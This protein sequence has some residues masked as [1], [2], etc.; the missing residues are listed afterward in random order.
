MLIVSTRW[1]VVTGLLF[2][3]LAPTPAAEAARRSLVAVVAEVFQSLVDSRQRRLETVPLVGKLPR[4]GLLARIA[5][6]EAG[7][8]ER[9][10]A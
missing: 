1:F 5:F 10:Q 4:G 3:G 2:L 7:V 6:S 8:L 9:D